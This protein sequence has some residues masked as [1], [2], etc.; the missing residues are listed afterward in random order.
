MKTP[1]AS[2]RSSFPN[3]HFQMQK[4]SLGRK[5]ESSFPV[6]KEAGFLI[7]QITIRLYVILAQSND[8]RV[9]EIYS[10]TYSVPQFPHVP[11]EDNNLNL[12]EFLSTLKKFIFK[13]FAPSLAYK[14]LSKFQWL[15]L[16]P[17]ADSLTSLLDLDSI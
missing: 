14:T 6:H 15:P 8:F 5:V 12:P 11:N 7:R 10:T 17:W 1:H 16:F 2:Q 9:R 3:Q 13:T 4:P